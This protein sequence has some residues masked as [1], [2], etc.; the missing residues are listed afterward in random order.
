MKTKKRLPALRCNSFV[1]EL[2]HLHFVKGGES[3]AAGC[4]TDEPP[5]LN[6][7]AGGTN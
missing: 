4:G 1:T 3:D 7:T 2:V 5:P 6:T